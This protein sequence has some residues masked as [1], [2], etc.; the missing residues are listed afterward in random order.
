MQTNPKGK[1]L[2]KIH[3]FLVAIKLFL[4]H[5]IPPLDQFKLSFQQSCKQK[6]KFIFQNIREN[7]RFRVKKCVT[8]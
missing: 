1:K 3:D 5:K 7:N 2:L 8:T 6:F 4:T